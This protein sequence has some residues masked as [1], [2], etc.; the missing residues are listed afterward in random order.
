MNYFVPHS[1]FHYTRIML[2]SWECNSEPTNLSQTN[3]MFFIKKLTEYIN[4]NNATKILVNCNNVVDIDDHFLDPI[5]DFLLKGKVSIHFFSTDETHNLVKYL[6]EHFDRDTKICVSILKDNETKVINL[7]V[8]E[9]HGPDIFNF[10]K[11]SLELERNGVKEIV[12]NSYTKSKKG[13]ILSST[14]L[15]P[16]G[17]FNASEIISDPSKF[18]WLVLL[19]VEAIHKV[20][21]KDKPKKYTIVASSLRGS[22]IAGSVK[23][24]LHFLSGPNLYIIDHIGP[25]H[26]VIEKP[27]FNNFSNSDYCVYIGDFLIAGT[28]LKITQAYCS[29][30]G[31][32]IKHAF[33]IGQ[34]TKQKKLWNKINLHSLVKLTD[35][36]SDLDYKLG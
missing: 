9:N 2:F 8:N 20:V 15:I 35:C 28:E 30:L 3:G 18:R 32:N 24:L 36:V 26:D 5:K 14:P 21:Q 4:S 22:A 19:L 29:F 31:G 23:E 11:K 17:Q 10:I 25:N 12:K 34:F 27:I 1:D 33:V 16:T 7:A 13:E 6:D